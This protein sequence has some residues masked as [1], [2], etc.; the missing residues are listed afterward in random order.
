MC[1]GDSLSLVAN[2]A[3]T[4]TWS[5]G[6]T[7]SLVVVKPGVSTSY[8]LVGEIGVGCSDTAQVNITVNALPSLSL[9]VSSK[10]IC[11]GE[12]TSILINGANTYTWSTAAT[13]TSISVSPTITTTYS[14]IGV[15]VNMCVSKDSVVMVVSKCDAISEAA[16][17]TNLTKVYPNPNHGSFVIEMP[18]TTNAEIHI[19][20]MLG[21]KILSTKAK[22]INT[23][24]LLG[25]D[26]GIYFIHVTQNNTIVYRNSI[27]KE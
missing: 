1:S 19:S 3:N 15:D 7:N 5:T 24:D 12:N 4:Y 18:E 22:S 16:L 8:T 11:L 14:V 2:G 23:I 17:I 10:T 13:A 26:N 25:F 27:I 21:Q 20:N 6:A 9:T